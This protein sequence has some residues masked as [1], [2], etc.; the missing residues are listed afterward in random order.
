MVI[1]PSNF[2]APFPTQITTASLAAAA[3][4]LSLLAVSPASC[5]PLPYSAGDGPP[6]GSRAVSGEYADGNAAY[7]AYLRLM[8][9]ELSH[10]PNEGPVALEEAPVVPASAPPSRARAGP[11][12]YVDGM[13]RALSHSRNQGPVALRGKRQCCDVRCHSFCTSVHRSRRSAYKIDALEQLPLGRS[14]RVST[15][16]M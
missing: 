1:Q 4:A 11:F 8:Q 5:N 14:G 3:A 9:K 15:L 10:S 12:G 6:A 2:L 7:Q 16:Y 13:E